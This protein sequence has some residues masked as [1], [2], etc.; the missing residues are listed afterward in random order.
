MV[1]TGTE[2]RKWM[3]FKIKLCVYVVAKCYLSKGQNHMPIANSSVFAKEQYFPRNVTGMDIE[4]VV[5]S[6]CF[7][8]F[9]A[10]LTLRIYMLVSA[11]ASLLRS[12]QLKRLSHFR[13]WRKRNLKKKKRKKV[14]AIFHLNTLLPLCFDMELASASGI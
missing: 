11:S 13:E 14:D 2:V 10:S 3:V 7:Q 6:T 12:L 1:Q 9:T 5:L 4:P 8:L